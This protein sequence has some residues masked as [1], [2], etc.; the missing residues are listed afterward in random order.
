VSEERA[1]FFYSQNTRSVNPFV[2]DERHRL[3]ILLDIE[4]IN[5]RIKNKC[6]CISFNQSTGDYQKMTLSWPPRSTGSDRRSF[7]EALCSFQADKSSC[8]DFDK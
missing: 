3:K 8:K 2:Y 6:L 5:F 4:K 7:S 1:T